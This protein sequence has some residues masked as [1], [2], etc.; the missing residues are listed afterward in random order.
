MHTQPLGSQDQ[1]YVQLCCGQGIQL[2]PWN[3]L[4]HKVVLNIAGAGS[5]RLRAARALTSARDATCSANAAL[6]I[7]LEAAFF[8]AALALAGDAPPSGSSRAE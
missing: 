6:V 5:R 3:A 4:I 1:E 2:S 8:V 7:F